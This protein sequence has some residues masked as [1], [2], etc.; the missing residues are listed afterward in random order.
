MNLWAVLQF[1]ETSF[2][3]QRIGQTVSSSG[4]GPVLSKG[5]MA[6]YTAVDRTRRTFR[7]VKLI[8]YINVNAAR[9]SLSL[10][11]KGRFQ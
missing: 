3:Q 7:D 10:A 4:R 8:D 6:Q 5:Y 1:L 9:L 2:L 11:L